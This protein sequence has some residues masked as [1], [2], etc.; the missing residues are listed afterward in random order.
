MK[1][2][3]NVKTYQRQ[4]RHTKGMGRQLRWQLLSLCCWL[5]LRQDTVCLSP[6][7]PPSPPPFVIFSIN[8]KLLSPHHLRMTTAISCLFSKIEVAATKY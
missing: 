3:D 4:G 5:S 1:L 6:L 8:I 2:S 7:L